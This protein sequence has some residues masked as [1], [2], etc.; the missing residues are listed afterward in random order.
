[1]SKSIIGVFVSAAASGAIAGGSFALYRVINESRLPMELSQHQAAV[2]ATAIAVAALALV[3]F[4][5]RWLPDQNKTATLEQSMLAII[6]GIATLALVSASCSLLMLAPTMSQ[7][8]LVPAIVCSV[9]AALMSIL[10]IGLGFLHIG[11]Q[12]PDFSPSKGR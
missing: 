7:L 5:L 3:V 6:A 12:V 10:P 4:V 9:L 1:M 11:E 2:A 8:W